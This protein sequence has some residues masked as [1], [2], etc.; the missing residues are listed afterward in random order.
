[1]QTY[2]IYGIYN[3]VN[4]KIYIGQTNQGYIKRFKQH[5]CPKDG[6]P[7]L[8]NA[9][10]K[11]GRD[12]FSCELLDVAETRESA[13]A[14]E[15]MW[16]YL[17]Q[18]FKPE[19]GYNLSMGGVIGDFNAETRKKMSE[20]KRGARNSFYGK[21]HSEETRRK[22]SSAKKGLYIRGKHPKAKKV[23]CVETGKI[24]DCVIDAQEDTGANAHHIGTVANGG[25]RK[26]AGGFKWEWV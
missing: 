23:R 20:S 21:H 4:N 9:I 2:G 16:I 17:L 22:M 15:K 26:M 6:S 7:A 10:K 13:N 19:N 18:T 12:S 24:Y 8:R 25:G 1:M 3:H 11:Y 14:K 5:L